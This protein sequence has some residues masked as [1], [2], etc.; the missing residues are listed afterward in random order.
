MTSKTCVEEKAGRAWIRDRRLVTRAPSDEPRNLAPA[1]FGLA[2]PAL[3][4]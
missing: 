2:N 1:R 4:V 3:I